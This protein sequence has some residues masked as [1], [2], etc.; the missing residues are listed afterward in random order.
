[1]KFDKDEEEMLKKSG[2]ITGNNY[3]IKEWDELFWVIED[4]I[5]KV[6]KLQEEYDDLEEDLR[7]NYKRIPMDY[8]EW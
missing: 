8:M 3:E 2:D 6:E 5:D 7:Q 4:L 1:M